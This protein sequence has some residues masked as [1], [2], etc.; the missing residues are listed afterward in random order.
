LVNTKTTWITDKNIV[1]LK[2]SRQYLF[3]NIKATTY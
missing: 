2:K 3:K 1:W